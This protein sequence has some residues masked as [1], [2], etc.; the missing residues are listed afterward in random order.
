[1][2]VLLYGDETPTRST[3]ADLLIDRGHAVTVVTAADEA[4]SAYRGA[5]PQMIVLTPG[6]AESL[7]FGRAVS[8]AC[9]GQLLVFVCAGRS[10]RHIHDVFE[11]GADDCI[12]ST[13]NRYRLDR[14]FTFIEQYI[15]APPPR[16]QRARG[17]PSARQ[18]AVVAEIGRR[19]LA[20]TEREVLMAYAARKVAGGLGVDYCKV[21]KHRPDRGQFLLK[22]GT[23]WKGDLIGSTCL[24]DGPDVQAGFTLR[25]DGP[26]VA[27]ALDRE[28]R[29]EPPA[30]LT[31][32]GIRAGMSV[33]IPSTPVS[34]GVLGAHTTDPD[35]VFEEDDVY[36]LQSVANVLA[37][38][39]ERS[40]TEQALRESEAKAR[41]VVETTV[42]G[43]IT[44]DDRARIRSFNRAAEEIFGYDEE[45]VLGENIKMLMPPPYHDEHDGYMQSYHETGRRRIIGIGREVMGRRKDGSTFPMDLAVSEVQL[46]DRQLFTGIVRDISERRKLEKEILNISEQERRRIGQDL[47]DGLGQMLTG[48]GLLGQNVARQLDSEDHALA[49]DV[50]EITDLIKEADQYARDLAHGLTPVDVDANGLSQALQRLSDNAVRLFDVPC[51]FEE[52]GTALVHDSTTATHLY[53]IAQEAVSNAVRHGDAT[54]ITIILA[55]GPDQIRVRIQ[56]DGVGFDPKAVDG[57]G[58][59]IHI[60]NYRARIVGG[61]LEINTDPGDGTTVTCT[62]PTAALGSAGD[63][64]GDAADD[65]AGDAHAANA[66]PA[67]GRA[68]GE[69]AA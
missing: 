22:A 37:G 14:R 24:G 33:V 55:S 63:A 45:E 57:P 10:P 35:R 48:I 25:S 68:A 67:A 6:D 20:G 16:L 26:V 21:L 17:E 54:Q 4:W 9:P 42:D 66:D 43:I 32:H 47:H 56:D 62:L 50:A 65:A 36:F 34:Y 13:E 44:I 8:E 52:V 59:G 61:N 53:R 58:M 19:A 31:E 12:I 49:G 11:A 5:D 29:F 23:G 46:G 7:T 39:V 27:D 2:T 18:Q 38:A 64:A 28:D 30:L 40:R 69:T 1:M 41:A 15:A 60:M 3:I 51:T